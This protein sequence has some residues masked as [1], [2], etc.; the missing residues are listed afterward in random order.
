MTTPFLKEL[1]REMRGEVRYDP[2]S[3]SVYSVDASIYEI[4]P[5][6]VASPLDREDLQIA[7]EVAARHHISL[8][9]RGAAT[10][11][12]GGCLGKGLVLDLSRHLNHIL[13]IDSVQKR[14]VCEPGV[15]QSDL[16]Q[17]LAPHGLRLGPDTS[18]GNRATLGGMLANN[19]AGA[20]SLRY[21]KM[22]DHIEEVSLLLA[23]GRELH[24]SPLSPSELQAKCALPTQEGEIYREAVRIRSTL[25]D[26]I[27]ARFPQIPRRVSGYNLDELL[28][29]PFNL[30]K[31]IAGAEGSLGIATT[32]TLSLSPLP[33]QTALCL[34]LF[35]SFEEA[36]RQ[37]PSILEWHP[38]ALELIDDKILT[39]GRHSPTLKNSF[40]WLSQMPKALLAVEFEPAET[41]AAFLAFAQKNQI[42]TLC[43]SLADPLEIKQFWRLREAGLGLLLSKRSYS[44]AIAFLEDVAVAPDQLAFFIRDFLQLLR[45]HGKEAGIYGHA[46]AGCLHIRP[47]IDLREPKEI[48]LIPSLMEETTRLLVHY[49]GALS[50]EH[51][52]GLVRSWLNEALF[53][54]PL[55]EAFRGLKKAFDPE[56]RMNPGKVVALQGPIENLRLSPETKQA[57]FT[58]QLDFSAEGGIHLAV[59]LC[60]GNGLC[61]KQE[62]V[63]CPSFHATRDERHTTRARAQ[64][65]RALLN[66]QLP[67]EMLTSQEMYEVMEYCIE[68]KGCKREC[69]SQVDMAKMKAEFLYHYHSRHGLPWRSF[70][71]GHLGALYAWA[72]PLSSLLNGLFRTRGGKKLLSIAGIAQKR[73]LPPLA[74][75]RFSRHLLPV[76]QGGPSVVLFND[77]YTEFLCPEIGVAAHQLLTRLGFSVIVPNWSCCGRT[78]LSKGMLTQAKEKAKQLFKQLLPFTQQNFPIILLEPS[79]LSMLKDDF[80]G[81]LEESAYQKLSAHCYS[82]EGFLAHYVPSF[83]SSFSSSLYLHTHCHQKALSDPTSPSRFFGSVLP[84]CAL[85]EIDSGCCGLAGSFGYE[86][87]HYALSLKIGEQRL[88]PAVREMPSEG[89][90]LANGFSCRSQIAHGTGKQALHLAQLL[91]EHF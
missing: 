10:G 29:P 64:S 90:L 58:S 77:T 37:I 61:R 88:F 4:P 21:G 69:P 75:Q 80:R 8:I 1:K 36:F 91:Y 43:V 19:A 34:L 38:F 87:E 40:P 79:C 18:T 16:N 48:A 60:N 32:L 17:A 24:F 57:P 44:R 6:A 63:M 84:K 53:G 59:D 25:S 52:D 45:A 66:G 26:E 9:P 31:L 86:K 68:C 39:A 73:P 35:S 14:A 70:L 23:S 42:G 15:V 3:L 54:T 55:Y 81:L 49:Q 76:F 13:N 50:G 85:H 27:R 65:L 5:Q 2:I 56:G 22:V 83:S 7:V 71:F 30:S 20:H 11:I 51:G 78:L 28:K 89:L 72:S 12:A 46:G 74:S 41:C 82:L 62:G 33:S 47:Y 67:L